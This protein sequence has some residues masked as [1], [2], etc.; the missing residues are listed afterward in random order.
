VPTIDHTSLQLTLH[1]LG[2]DEQRGYY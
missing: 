2:T 1:T